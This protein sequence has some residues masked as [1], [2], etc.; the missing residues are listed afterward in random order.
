MVND[1][2]DNHVSSDID[3]GNDDNHSDKSGG[4][5]SYDSSCG[6]DLDVNYIFK[7]FNFLFDK[8]LKNYD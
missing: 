6:E 3:D 8:S 7:I 2:N 5:S 4:C 1:S